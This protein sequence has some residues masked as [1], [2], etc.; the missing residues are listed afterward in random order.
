MAGF[1]YRKSSLTKDE[2]VLQYYIVA[3]SEVITIGDA[4]N[5]NTSG[6]AEV[7]DA[8]DKVAGIVAQLVDEN[9]QPVD[10]DTD[11]LDT[12]TVPSTNQTVAQYKVGIMMSKN[13]AYYNDADD[14]LATTNLLQ[15]FD[16]VAAGDQIDASTASDTAGQFQLI[17]LDPDGDADASKGLF[18][19]AESQLDP[20]AQQ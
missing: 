18:R 5:L 15:F 16:T 13:I 14:T 20:Y 17:S 10:H 3:N 19:I 7:V 8:G 6:F 1:H 9:G 12:W 4:V 11:T 2:P